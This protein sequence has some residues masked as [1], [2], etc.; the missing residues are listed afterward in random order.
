VPTSDPAH[1]AARPSTGIPPVKRRSGRRGVGAHRETSPRR[2]VAPE[3]QLG[4][5]LM[6]GGPATPG[7]RGPAKAGPSGH[8]GT[9]GE[10]GRPTKPMKPVKRTAAAE[11]AE[12]TAA[13]EPA[14]PRRRAG[15][16]PA[17][18]GTAPAGAATRGRSAGRPEPTRRR[19]RRTRATGPIGTVRSDVS[20][21]RG[22]YRRRRL[23][24][25][26]TV[27]GLVAGVVAGTVWLAL[28]VDALYLMSGAFFLVLI[29]VLLAS[30]AVTGRSPHVLYRP[31]QVDVRLSDVH[32]IGAVT[33]DVRR[34][35]DLFLSAQTFRRDFGG[36]ARRGLLFEGPPGTGKTH[37]AKAMA[38]EAGVPFLFVSATA[39]QSMMYGATA[40][41]IRAY[42]RALHRAA[43]AEGGAI[44]FIEEI[45]AIGG[46]RGGVAAATA[47]PASPA[48][49]ASGALCCGGLTGLPGAPAITTAAL[50]GP[51]GAGAVRSALVSSDTGAVVNELLVQLQSFDG[52]TPRQR[53][54]AAVTEIV[55]LLLPRRLALPMPRARA[56]NVLIIAATNRADALDP[57]LLR[58]GRF[59]RRLVFDLP[60]KA[61]R[62]D[63]V[64]HFLGR[65]AH[66]PQLDDDDYR[67]ALAGITQ[68]YSPAK[69][70][71]LLDEALVNTVRR[72]GAGMSWHDIES[73]RLVTEVGLGRPV[74]YTDHEQRLIATHEAG[75][76]VIAWLLAPQRRLEVLTIVKR[77]V[78]L[79][80]LQHGDREDV[81]TRSRRELEVLVAIAFGGQVAEELFFGDVSTGPS[82]DLAFATTVAAQM[83]GQSG[84]G[85]TLVSFVAA[86]ASAL[87][88]GDLVSRVLGD[89]VA[90][91]LVES[92]LA[93]QKQ[94]AHALLAS[95]RH[96]VTALRD[97]LLERHELIGHEIEDVLTAARD[98]HR[99]R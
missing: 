17:G 10:S 74:A 53:A 32:G 65:K 83:V 45:D 16:R 46:T 90:R 14:E 26:V 89:T 77:G 60:D 20:R 29:V 56:A 42:F 59:D 91:E 76:A 7:S 34:S 47:H 72:G 4:A 39:F 23:A 61:G 67:D 87:G 55:N 2:T 82:G 80:L 58:P 97:A 70:E 86:P 99:A 41:K 52:L 21:G 95:H 54:Q 6:A 88:G 81:Y 71:H 96:L 57:A 27:A 43:R 78:A 33:E 3:S 11:P 12:P 51:A 25:V 31:E 73:A 37:L 36:R 63:L 49:V 79:G 66:E 92:L 94:E 85:S 68:G 64:D 93:R 24:Q 69:I 75:H 30:T 44:G 98:A 18:P 8:A 1:D 9:P 5:P 15:G 50:A 13:A 84:M 38:A 35:L 62:R 48:D 28:N 19:F 40:R 22:R